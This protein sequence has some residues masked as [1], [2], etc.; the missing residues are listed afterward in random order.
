VEC[1]PNGRNAA[2]APACL[3]HNI[4]GFPTWEIGTARYTEVLQPGRLAALSGYTPEAGAA[5]R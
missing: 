1:Y 5:S 3:E 4:S 2:R